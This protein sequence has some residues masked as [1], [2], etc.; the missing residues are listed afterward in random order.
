MPKPAANKLALDVARLGS[1]LDVDAVRRSPLGLIRRAN[2][3]YLTGWF[4]RDLAS[5]LASFSRSVAAGLS[6]RLIVNVPPRHGKTALLSALAAWHL[7]HHPAHAIVYACYGQDLAHRASKDVRPI[8]D[9]ATYQAAFPR[10]SVAKGRDNIGEWETTEGGSFKAVGVGGPLVGRGANVLVIDDPHKNALEGLSPRFTAKVWDWYGSAAKTRLAPGGGVI[11]CH[12]RWSTH[13]LTGR[14]LDAKSYEEDGEGQVAR[15]ERVI[16]A[17]IA[18][19]DEPHR[20][21]GEALHPERYPLPALKD[22]KGSMSPSLWAAV[23][24]QSPR[25]LSSG[26]ASELLK[27]IDHRDLPRHLSWV[28]AWDTATTASSGG[29]FTAGILAAFDSTAQR[30]YLASPQ[31]R[32]LEAPAVLAFIEEIALMDGAH[33]PIYVEGVASQVSVVQHLKARPRLLPHQIHGVS[34]ISDKVTASVG[35]RTRAADGDLYCVR[36]GA[37]EEFVKQWAEFGAGEHDDCVDAVSRATEA[38]TKESGDWLTGMVGGMR[39]GA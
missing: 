14:L 32:R 4:H 12:Q 2:P 26:V 38:L 20:Q 5:R 34:K 29:D 33:V 17:A 1:S 6:P 10:A 21:A 3:A 15:W 28:R 13:D 39:R 30:L 35:W 23:A 25:H 7:G 36:G 16:Y 19:Q 22:W 11:I 27:W 37:W 18:T 24:Q 31:A 8:L 9:L